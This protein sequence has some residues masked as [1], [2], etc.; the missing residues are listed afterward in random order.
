MIEGA[1][2]IPLKT[3]ESYRG[4]LV[5]VQHTYPVITPYLKGFHLTIDS[6][7]PDRDKEGWRLP[8]SQPRSGPYPTPPS[9]VCAVPRFRSDVLALLSLFSAE[10]PP[11]RFVRSKAIHTVVYGFADASGGGF[12]STLGT[13][14][15]TS[16]THGIWDV[17]EGGMSSNF[18]ELSNLVVTLEQGMETGQLHLTEVWIFT[19]NSVSESVFWHGHSSSPQL[20]SLI[21]RLWQVEMS[22]KVHIHMVHVPGT[23]MFEQGTDGLSHGDVNEGVMTGTSILQY[24]PLHLSAL[25]RQPSIVTWLCTWIPEQAA[26]FLSPDDWFDSGHGLQFG[27]TDSV[28]MWVS[29]ETSTSWFVWSPPPSLADVALDEL[30]ESRHKRKHLNHLWIA[31]RLMTYLWQKQ[32]HKICDIV[33]SIPPGSRPFWPLHEH[34]PLLVGLTLRFSVFSPWQTKFTTGVLDLE[35]A[36]STVWASLGEHERDLLREFRLTPGRMD[37]MPG[38]VV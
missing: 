25:D 32:L 16:Y 31:P 2:P 4:S 6:W 37:G 19:D 14:D 11:L 15:S 34:E 35:R 12:G 22:G 5:Y 27:V 9:E 8:K 28:G 10:V 20:S 29:G 21:L 30:E 17:D 24:V 7:R 1:T 3:L 36:L 38:R 18:R 13:D 33:F 23:Q 26:H